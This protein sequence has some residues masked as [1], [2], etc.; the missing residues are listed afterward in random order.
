MAKSSKGRVTEM[1]NYVMTLIN[2]IAN[3]GN[4]TNISMSETYASIDFTKSGE[5]Y[6]VTIMKEEKK[7]DPV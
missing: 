7:N 3:Y 1:F 2:A 5:K 4:I 6:L